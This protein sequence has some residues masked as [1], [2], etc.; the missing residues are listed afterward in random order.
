MKKIIP[1]I[2]L[3]FVYV[4]TKTQTVAN[5]ENVF[6]G[7]INAIKGAPLNN[8][9]TDTFRIV[10]ST[11]S[12]NSIFYANAI[13]PL[14]GGTVY[15]DS[16]MVLPSASSNAGLGSGIQKIAYHQTSQKIFFISLGNIYS[17]SLTATAATAITT[18][19]G[20]TDLIVKGDKIFTLSNNG[21][22]TFSIG[23]LDASGNVTIISTTT[24][25]GTPYSSIIAGY[26]DKLYGFIGG[27]DPQAIQFGGT[28][29]TGINLASTTID[30]MPSIPASGIWGAMNVYTD[31][32][33]F[34]GGND[35]TGK[36]IAKTTAFNTA[37]TTILTGIA[38]IAG[39][40]IDFR[41]TTLGNYY[42]YFGS[43]YSNNK[44]SLGSWLNFGNTSFETHPNDGAV[45]F[46]RENSITGGVV[47]LTTDQGLGI[48]KNSGSIITEVDNGIN[49]VQ[50]NDFDME[51]TKNVGWLASKTGIRYVTNY[52]TAAKSWSNA[53]FP[54]NDGSPYYSCEMVNAD[55]V[56]VGN[57]RVY[58]TNNR[59]NNWNQIFT[60]ENA[61]YNFGNYSPRITSLAVGGNSNEIILAGYKLYNGARGGVFYSLDKGNSWNQLLINASV[62]GQDVNVN[63]IEMTIDS[64]QIVA[65]IGV[66]Y[67]NSTSPIIKG[68]YKAQ[69]NGTIWTVSSEPIYAASSSLITVNDIHIVSKDTIVAVGAFYN[70]TLHREYP[71]HFAISRTIKNT[72]SSSVVDTGRVG[73]YNAVSWNGDTIFYSYS[74]KIY[75]DIIKFHST[76]T[77]RKGEALYYSVPVGTEIN[78]LFYDELLAGTETDI[79]SVRG[80]GTVKTNTT[81]ATNKRG[82]TNSVISGGS[83]AGGVYYIVDTTADGYIREVN[84]D[85]N[86]LFAVKGVLTGESSSSFTS[87]SNALAAF[88]TLVIV[89]FD[90]ITNYPSTSGTII[91]AYSDASLSASSDTSVTNVSA[92]SAISAITGASHSCGPINATSYLYNSTSGG[93]WTSSNVNVA[94]MNNSGKI[95]VTGLGSTVVNYTVNNTNGCSSIATTNFV[96]SGVPNV[97]PITGTNQVCVGA[98]AQLNN[99]TSLP[100]NTTAAWESIAGRATVSNTGQVT[101]TSAG[102]AVIKYTATNQYGCSSFAMY[103][104]VVNAIPAVPLVSYAIGTINPQYGAPAGGF[105][106]G[107]TFSLIGSP[108][109]GVFSAS[110]A[111][112]VTNAG[113]V[114]IDAL[115]AGSITYKYTNVQGCSNKRI[116]TGNGV[117]CASRSANSNEKFAIGNI[118][119]VMYPNPAR[120]QFTIYQSQLIG[121]GTIVVTDLYG[122]KVKTQLLSIGDNIVDVTM[123]SKGI[124]FVSVVTNAQKNTQKL[125][126]E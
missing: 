109:G 91:I 122:K 88:P 54:N 39:Y 93:T 79:R 8:S 67:D 65:Y 86:I 104:I 72:W 98:S 7:T 19:G 23:N 96:V 56:F 125:I 126:I 6:G 26:D 4:T 100:I 36:L 5:V 55:T 51:A 68:M 74:N 90:V 60:A 40:N 69:W 102:T 12:A 24:I 59:G 48:S 113:V 20:Y 120:S 46:A 27:N 35:N 3:L 121:S 17:S 115:G 106:R 76:Y 77:S 11:Q 101:G 110:G 97:Q 18:S 116:I 61:P 16:F 92:S 57:S 9:G 45:F 117:V 114:T 80:A 32:T 123:L 94:T 75:W 66:D 25:A 118:D 64:G 37:Y 82:C 22:S 15:L 50:V 13:I 105:C 31:G 38:G 33:V 78:V 85:F 111:A 41:P 95:T 83:P 47:F 29:S 52:N 42:V 1:L 71:I 28:F 62:I 99:N 119:F 70:P 107:K 124:Y 2:V 14:T 103:N 89:A 44:G 43:A 87:N 63:D 73:G 49:A 34:V 21:G 84:G 112:S 108:N 81:L 10:I 58:K 53:I 30:P